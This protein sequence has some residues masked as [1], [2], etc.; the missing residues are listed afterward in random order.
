[1][2]SLRDGTPFEL[3]AA[4]APTRPVT[5]RELV[6]VSR[7][8]E[9][10]ALAD[11]PPAIAA[12]LQDVRF[13]TERT[14]AVY[15]RLAEVGCPGR[16]HGRGLQSWL[17]PGVTGVPL[18]DDDPLVDEWVLVVPDRVLLAAADLHEADADDDARS[19]RYA[20]VRE[21]DAVSAAA[22]LLGL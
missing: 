18:D 21:P 17:S 11:P 19:F 5:K 15:A 4:A 3:V 8:I 14:R 22:R 6:A 16:L 10:E 13:L 7:T 12:C 9:R 20:V 1:M 2:T